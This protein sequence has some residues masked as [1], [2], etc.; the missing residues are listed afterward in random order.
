[1]ATALRKATS[2]EREISEGP[3]R[4]LEPL[5]APS[6]PFPLECTVPAEGG[7]SHGGRRQHHER[8]T[9]GTITGRSGYECACRS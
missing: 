4:E 6:E 2:L 5:E 8:T 1:M 3:P 9:A 7:V